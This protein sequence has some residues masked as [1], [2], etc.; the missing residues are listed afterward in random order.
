MEGNGNPL[1]TGTGQPVN[2]EPSGPAPQ[3]PAPQAEPT[4]SPAPQTDFASRLAELEQQNQ[5]YKQLSEGS[6]S[7]AL[8]LKQ[9]LD[10]FRADQQKRDEQQ[11][12]IFQA[13]SGGQVPGQHQAPANMPEALNRYYQ[14]DDQ[15]VL[16]WERAL[17]DR[18]AAKTQEMFT[19]SLRPQAHV[20]LMQRDHGPLVA[21]AN[22]PQ[23]AQLM[24]KY[25]ELV[26]DPMTRMR[27]SDDPSAILQINR[28]GGREQAPVDMRILYE[29]GLRVKAEQASQAGAQVGEQRANAPMVEGAGAVT[30]PP[31][32]EPNHWGLLTPDE[33]HA[34]RTGNIPSTWPKTEAAAAKHM[35]ELEQKHKPRDYEARLVRAKVGLG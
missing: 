8:R 18:I 35:L 16:A 5:R 27:Y 21:D 25:E 28:P 33:Q 13:L 26:A 12:A 15:A 20:Q 11:R 19:Q 17:D 32:R 31:A 9:E 6:K 14:G 34:V 10:T 23:Y 1:E 22:S 4:P 2:P 24:T 3:A 7:E 29:A 30:P